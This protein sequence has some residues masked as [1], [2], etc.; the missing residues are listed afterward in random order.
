MNRVFTSKA[1]MKFLP[2]QMLMSSEQFSPFKDFKS[3]QIQSSSRKIFTAQYA[4]RNTDLNLAVVA[5]T[6]NGFTFQII[7]LLMESWGVRLT[8]LDCD[9]LKGT[10]LTLGEVSLLMNYTT[11]TIQRTFMDNMEL[12]V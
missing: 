3:D 9:L 5:G 4:C 12:H 8:S 10:H 11:P 2:A 7:N 1:V 6:T